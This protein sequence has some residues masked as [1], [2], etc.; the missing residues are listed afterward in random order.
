MNSHE[1]LKIWEAEQHLPSGEPMK[2]THTALRVFFRISHSWGLKPHEQQL[3][4]AQSDGK[5]LECWRR[6]EGPALEREVLERIS[7][8]LGIYKAL[9]CLFPIPEQADAWP[10]KP[11][12]HFGGQP[13]IDVM[14]A[15]GVHGLRKVR[16]YL[17]S[18]CT[19]AN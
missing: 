5:R 16:R 10:K 18:F 1:L 7:L 19:G 14:K 13:A 12:H 15:D 2:V 17:D 11:N 8:I 4:L 3:F 9:H 6:S